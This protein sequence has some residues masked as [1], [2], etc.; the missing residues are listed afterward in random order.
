MNTEPMA[1]MI[2]SDEN[3]HGRTVRFA[4][5]AMAMENYLYLLSA[6]SCIISAQCALRERGGYLLI[7]AV[8]GA[9]YADMGERGAA[10]SAREGIILRADCEITLSI[11]R[12]ESDFLELQ[13]FRM[14]GVSFP[15]YFSQLTLP[16]THRPTDK[17]TEIVRFRAEEGSL[18]DSAIRKLSDMTMMP[19]K[20]QGELVASTAMISLLTELIINRASD[21]GAARSM[22]RYI[23]GIMRY[24]NEFYRRQITLDELAAEFNVSKFHLS[25]E[26]KKYTGFSPNEYII[27]VRI[28]RAKELLR[29]T[30][31]TITEIAQITGCGDVN[32]FIQLFKSR[33][34][35]TPAV[36]RRRWNHDGKP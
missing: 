29:Y 18:I 17:T 5:S 21:G 25:R 30:G 3:L 20:P 34:K 16:R 31:R 19:E 2:I 8:S 33:E 6:A 15:A 24:I 1:D 36:F 7:Y 14:D 10:I 28:S 11:N 22:P 26:F 13:I 9:G 35:V 23:E 32:H 27:S 12:R 4:P